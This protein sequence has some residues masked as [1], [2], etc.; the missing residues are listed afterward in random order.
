V[1]LRR[2]FSPRGQLVG[3]QR[4]KTAWGVG[5]GGTTATA[6][7]SSSAVLVGAGAAST[8]EGSTVVRIRGELLLTLNTAITALDAFRGAFGIGIVQNPAFTAGIN[9][10]PSPITEEDDE[11]W[12][13]HRYFALVAPTNEFVG[14][15]FARI[16]IDSKAMRK[17]DS[18]RILYGAIEVVE[19]G[20]ATM[21]VSFNS[22]VLV[23]LA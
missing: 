17:F 15:T 7:S 3:R 19:V 1:A 12:L 16:E 21:D 13:Y 14:N 6:I 2:G 23:K 8:L 5:P 20:D 11:N 10:V 18:D 9:S 4:R 22:R